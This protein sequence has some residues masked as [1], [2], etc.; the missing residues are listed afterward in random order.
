[1]SLSVFNFLFRINKKICKNNAHRYVLI[2]NII[3]SIFLSFANRIPFF[4]SICIVVTL[5]YTKLQKL[6]NF[7]LVCSFYS[8]LKV[9]SNKQKNLNYILNVHFIIITQDIRKCQGH[10]IRIFKSSFNSGLAI[11]ENGQ[12][13]MVQGQNKSFLFFK[14]NLIFFTVVLF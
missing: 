2:C 5:R 7:S 9:P 4:I 14:Y 10:S 12:L 6:K 8:V 13:C 3:F 11:E 1:M